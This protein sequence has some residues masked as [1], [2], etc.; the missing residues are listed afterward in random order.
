MSIEVM[1][2]V[3]KFSKATGRAKLVLLGIANHQ[4][5]EG[6]W[7]SIAT[8][9]QYANASERSV[10]RD[11]QDLIDLGEL[12]VEINAAPTG[13]QYRTNRYW[14]LVGS[15]VTDSVSGV[16]NQVVRGDSSGNQGCQI[17]SSG[18]TPVGTQNIINLKRNLNEIYAQFEQFW[19]TYP[20]K[21]SKKVAERV[22]AG[23]SDQQRQDALAGAVRL[24][25]D[26]NL[27]D[28]TYVPHPATWLRA[29]RWNDAPYPER[30]LSVDELRSLELQRAAESRVKADEKRRL[31]LAEMAEN[32]RR[33]LESPP[34]KCVH[35]RVY[36]ACMPCIK[37]GIVG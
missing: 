32:E 7:P 16:T 35:G 11:I 6:A 24:S 22:W 20:R 31:L 8:L 25:N 33:A 37:S 29:E 2:Q 14:V 26:P 1:T 23:F 21:V 27:P 15:G 28:L 5:D 12:R 19:D 30:K 36:A 17:G 18:V 34:D 4:G 10:K 13:G 9:A 3:L